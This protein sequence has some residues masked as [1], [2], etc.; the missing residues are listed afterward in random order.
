MVWIQ[1]C[2]RV[3]QTRAGCWPFSGF[4][5]EDLVTMLNLIHTDPDGFSSKEEML[6]WLSLSFSFKDSLNIF[7]VSGKSRHNWMIRWRK[8]P[9]FSE[10]FRW[11]YLNYECN[12]KD[13]VSKPVIGCEMWAHCLRDLSSSLR[14][15]TWAY[16]C[17]H[18]CTRHAVPK[19]HIPQETL[20]C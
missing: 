10:S 18:A 14:N 19:Q 9:P 6:V 12:G 1:R 4:A 15:C 17:V 20:E 13:V 16:M 7:K 8:L 11:N 5:R 3:D 2:G